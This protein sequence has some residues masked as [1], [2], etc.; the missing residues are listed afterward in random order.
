[1]TIEVGISGG[2]FVPSLI[3]GTLTIAAGVSGT[4]FTITP[5]TGERARLTS[6]SSNSTET[7][8]QLSVGGVAIISSKSLMQ[9]PSLAGSYCVSVAGGNDTVYNMTGLI[10]GIT[11]GINE[12][13]V[14]SLTSG[15][16]AGIIRYAYM[17]GKIR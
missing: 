9:V 17:T 7:N 6:V 13:I 14:F 16:T 11:G 15:S 3:S 8:T 2:T 4:I 10:D 1:M 12:A 5:P